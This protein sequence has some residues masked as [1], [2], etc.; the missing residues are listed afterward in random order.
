[1]AHPSSTIS[2]GR[3]ELREG[4]SIASSLFNCDLALSMRTSLQTGQIMP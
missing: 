4:T 2:L 3:M 1:M